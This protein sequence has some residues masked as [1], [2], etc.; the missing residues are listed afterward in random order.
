[1]VVLVLSGAHTATAATTYQQL[2]AE[3]CR[4]TG[5][6][7]TGGGRTGWYM[8]KEERKFFCRFRGILM[9]KGSHAGNFL[10]DGKFHVSVS[11]AE[12]RRNNARDPS[13]LPSYYEVVTSKPN[14]HWVG[15]CERRLN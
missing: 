15:R 7:Q 1:L 8:V 6:T 12:L 3:G 2:Q 14:P 9:R 4:N 11:V 5:F 13:S 10:L